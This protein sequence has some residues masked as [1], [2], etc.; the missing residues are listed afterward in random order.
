IQEDV[1]RRHRGGRVQNVGVATVPVDFAATGLERP[2]VIEVVRVS[3]GSAKRIDCVLN[4]GSVCSGRLEYDRLGEGVLC[5]SSLTTC[6][7]H[8]QQAE[9]GY[10]RRTNV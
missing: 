4:R 3:Q 8:R 9:G 1:E 7:Q 2:R 10:D 5:L 6:K